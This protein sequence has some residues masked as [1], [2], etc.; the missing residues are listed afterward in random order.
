MSA[1]KVFPWQK[2][3]FKYTDGII[4]LHEEI[5]HYY[6]YVLP[7]PCEHVVRNEL[8]R[9][10]EDLVH[11]L[12]PQAVVE[13]FG[14]FRTGFV[15]P[16]SDIDIVIIG[17][18]EKLPL[19]TLES[20]LLARQYAESSTM[21]VLDMAHVPI[22]KF[23]DRETKIKVDISFNM[24]SGVHSSELVKVFK[25]DNPVLG[26]LLMVLKQFLQQRGLNELFTGGVSS[27]ALTTM[28]VSYL[29][30]HRRKIDPETANLGVLLLEFFELYGMRFCYS[31]VEISAANKGSYSRSI[32]SQ[33]SQVFIA[34][35]LEPSHNIGRG[36][37][38]I[39][40]IKQAFVWAYRVLNLALN[41]LNQ[42]LLKS[43]Q[44]SILGQIINI[45]NELIEQR[46]WLHKTFGHLVVV[47]QKADKTKDS[48]TVAAKDT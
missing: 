28:C 5:E 15:L 2:P 12:W 11:K 43:K 30:M 18:W 3:K 44:T 46:A 14:S 20:E 38:Q 25:A 19:R 33:R 4:G 37:H 34:D 16:N 10:I 21:F 1:T 26:K 6:E 27:Y 31:K 42:R 7:T 35:P 47:E 39:I 36:S 13:I 23:T 40:A 45:N 22:L 24:S 9:R 48:T 32:Q 29:Q 41:P 8:V 17:L